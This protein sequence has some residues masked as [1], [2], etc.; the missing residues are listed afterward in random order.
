MAQQP[1]Y[2]EADEEMPELVERLR[3]AQGAEVAIVL[4]NRSR[5]GQ[6]RF[7]FQLLREYAGR[8]GKTVAIISPEA[9]V[10]ALASEHG[11]SSYPSVDSYLPGA[12]A[13]APAPQP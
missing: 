13:Y 12:G 2:I 7:N 5:L 9:S 10:Q 11:F 8:M 3:A 4:P 6:S 1:I